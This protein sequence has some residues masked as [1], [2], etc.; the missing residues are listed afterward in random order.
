MNKENEEDEERDVEQDSET[1]NKDNRKSK[2]KGKKQGTKERVND[3]DDENRNNKQINSNVNDQLKYESKASLSIQVLMKAIE[4]DKECFKRGLPAIEK[5]RTIPYLAQILKTNEIA[6]YFL[7]G[8]GLNLIEEYFK[9]NPDGSVPCLNQIGKMLDIISGL[10]IVKEHLEDSNI[11]DVLSSL[12]KMNLPTQLENK[13]KVIFNKLQRISIGLYNNKV[14]INKENQVYTKYINKK[15]NNAK[16]EDGFSNMN[17]KIFYEKLNS[18]RRIPM[19]ALFDFTLKPEKMDI[20]PD[21]PNRNSLF[22]SNSRKYYTD[23]YLRLNEDH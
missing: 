4:K 14:D 19:K 1:L 17:A 5:L 23:K 9:K 22:T 18:E 20:K 12:F 3:F 15:R 11:L 13:A 8:N 2:S 10:N 7:N 21:D 6:S 16:N